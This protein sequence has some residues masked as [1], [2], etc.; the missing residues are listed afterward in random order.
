[1]VTAVL[2]VDIMTSAPMM[3]IVMIALDDDRNY[4]CQDLTVTGD[5]RHARFQRTGC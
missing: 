4:I 3:T 2:D 1:M 5:L